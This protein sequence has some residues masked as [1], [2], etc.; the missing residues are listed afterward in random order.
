MHAGI[1]APVGMAVR[2]CDLSTHNS[3]CQNNSDGSDDLFHDWYLRLA[4]DYIFLLLL[5]YIKRHATKKY[6]RNYIELLKNDGATA[7][8]GNCL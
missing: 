3:G 5:F 4:V 7:N 2:T 1:T 8:S 6:I